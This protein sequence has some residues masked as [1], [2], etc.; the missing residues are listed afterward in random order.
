MQNR[1]RAGRNPAIAYSQDRRII[2]PQAWE[3]GGLWRRLA[4]GCGGLVTTWPRTGI[5]VITFP[6][7]AQTLESIGGRWRGFSLNVTSAFA[8]SDIS[9][10]S[11]GPETTR[12]METNRRI[13]VRRNLFTEGRLLHPKAAFD[14]MLHNISAGGALVSVKHT[15]ELPRQF[16]LQIP[17][18]HEIRRPCVLAWRDGEWLGMKFLPRVKQRGVPATA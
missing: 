9:H 3:N 13:Y 8:T 16:I 17:G 12:G 7:D 18:N 15:G 4:T 10:T 5:C 11:R 14:C 2:Q 1:P 6:A